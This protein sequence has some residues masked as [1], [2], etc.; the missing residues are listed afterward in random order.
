MINAV[1]KRVICILP[2]NLFFYRK[3]AF[4]GLRSG[5]RASNLAAS[6]G[7]VKRFEAEI[8]GRRARG[9]LDECCITTLGPVGEGL[10][11]VREGARWLHLRADA[12][13]VP[14][15][16]RRTGGHEAVATPTG[17]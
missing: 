1:K 6:A 13:P 10:P 9:G 14:R 15:R 11:A 4:A 7:A 5:G 17:I 2:F 3:S 8:T 16:G 12:G